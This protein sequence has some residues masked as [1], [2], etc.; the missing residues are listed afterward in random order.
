MEERPLRAIVITT[1][2]S[3]EIAAGGAE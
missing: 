3:R 2:S 1:P